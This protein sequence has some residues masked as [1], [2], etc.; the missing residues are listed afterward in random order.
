MFGTV[1]A[2]LLAQVPAGEFQL[3]GADDA[4][5]RLIQSTAI[6]PLDFGRRQIHVVEVMR[7][8]SD[9]TAY[10]RIDLQIDC[11][12]RRMAVLSIAGYDVNAFELFS[13]PKASYPDLVA[14][15]DGS[16]AADYHRRVCDNDWRDTITVESPLSLID[17]IR[18][19]SSE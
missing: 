13:T 5:F 19:S 2:L 18:L 7:D 8:A 14:F 3:V 6:G 16:D 12:N 17:A 4:A 11:L 10:Q 15:A 9:P 1:F